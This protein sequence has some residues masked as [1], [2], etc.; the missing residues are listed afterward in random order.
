MNNMESSSIRANYIKFGVDDYY[1][2]HADT[3]RN[4]HEQV[5]RT[6]LAALHDKSIILKTDSVLDLAAG[7]GEVTRC[8]FNLGFADIRATEPFL[9]S[10]YEARTGTRCDRYSFDDITNGSY[11]GE[12]F[13]TIICSF[14]LHLLDKSKLPV[15]LYKLTQISNK[16]IIISPHKN[17]IIKDEHGWLLTDEMLID[18]VRTRVFVNSFS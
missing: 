14:A 11:D 4:P 12:H 5:I 17:P 16:L 1:R 8:L 6:S 3:Y 10:A 18:K 7:T 13:D 2:N 15:F 9:A